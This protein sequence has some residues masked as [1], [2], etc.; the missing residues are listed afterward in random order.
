MVM[1]VLDVV[2]APLPLERD[3]R[4]PPCSLA[5]PVSSLA[6]GDL[7][8][9]ENAADW[10]PGVLGIRPARTK[11]PLAISKVDGGDGTPRPSQAKKSVSIREV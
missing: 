5:Q 7:L 3:S 9:S 6:R 2:H 4:P 11:A 1:I 8:R 10:I